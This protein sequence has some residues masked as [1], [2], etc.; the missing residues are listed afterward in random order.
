MDHFKK[1]QTIQKIIKY[2][3]PSLLQK[4]NKVHIHPFD[5]Y[6]AAIILRYH[7]KMFIPFPRLILNSVY[8][9]EKSP[10]NFKMEF[11]N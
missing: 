6:S 1:I 3:L 9:Q 5:K 7:I 10:R 11:A 4:Q 2:L 8:S